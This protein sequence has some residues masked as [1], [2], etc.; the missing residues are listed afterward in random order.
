VK[1]LIPTPSLA[2]FRKEVDRF[3]DRVREGDAFDLLSSSD[4]IPN[5]DFSEKAEAFTV[6]LE[7]PGIEPKDIEVLFQNGMLTIRGQK[8]K[9][10]IEDKDARFYRSE[11]S[12]GSFV[13][14]LRMPAAIDEKLIAATF[15]NGVLTIMRRRPQ[16][17]EPRRSRSKSGDCLDSGRRDRPALGPA[18][19]IEG[20]GRSFCSR[21]RRRGRGRW[22]CGVPGAAVRGRQPDC[23]ARAS[24]RGSPRCCA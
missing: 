17:P 13:R 9:S 18:V 10:E 23:C 19:A 5:M 14:N 4:W 21:W 20:P 11:R 7:V 8:A 24:G 1:E 15:K 6:K 22:R 12:Y 3:L 2:N 16:R